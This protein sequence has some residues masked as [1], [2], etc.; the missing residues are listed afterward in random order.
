VAYALRR[1]RDLPPR[2]LIRFAVA[3]WVL[4]LGMVEL[5]IRIR[6]MIDKEEDKIRDAPNSVNESGA[7]DLSVHVGC[8]GVS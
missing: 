5:G 1:F 2:F 6:L 8:G 3:L 7:S 4:S